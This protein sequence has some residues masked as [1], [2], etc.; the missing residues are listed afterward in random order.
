MSDELAVRVPVTDDLIR[1][2]AD[3]V[4]QELARKRAL[5]LRPWLDVKG[6]AEYLSCPTGRI[7]A[8]TGSGRMRHERD[9][10]RLLFRREWLDDFVANGGARRP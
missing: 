5:E 10:R 2:V 3:R 7:Y 4:R 6:A 8:L 1:A 9:G